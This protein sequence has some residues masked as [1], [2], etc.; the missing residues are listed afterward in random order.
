MA[1]GNEHI[2]TV[3]SSPNSSAPTA[4]PARMLSPL[5]FRSNRAQTDLKLNALEFTIFVQFDARASLLEPSCNFAIETI[6][7]WCDGVIIT[8]SVCKLYRFNGKLYFILSLR[9]FMNP[10]V[11]WQTKSWIDYLNIFE[12]ANKLCNLVAIRYRQLAK[13]ATTAINQCESTIT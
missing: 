4:V 5:L 2:I 13:I 11:D 3:I 6:G 8:S 12:W 7:W 9:C 10:A 1:F